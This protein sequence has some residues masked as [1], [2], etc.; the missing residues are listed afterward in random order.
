[1]SGTPDLFPPLT[2]L[3]I[4]KMSSNISGVL[5]IISS[6]SAS[7]LKGVANSPLVVSLVFQNKFSIKAPPQK[8]FFYLILEVV[9]IS[10]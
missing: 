5:K 7:L 10:K 4:K 1:M 8:N 2:C 9:G 6:N 3:L